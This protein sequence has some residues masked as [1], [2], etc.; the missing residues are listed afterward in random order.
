MPPGQNYRLVEKMLT[1]WISKSMLD[2]DANGSLN[3]VVVQSKE[4]AQSNEENLN[5]INNQHNQY[6]KTIYADIDT[7]AETDTEDS[8]M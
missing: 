2:N 3:G 7:E 8:T 1:D 6:M 5:G 4:V